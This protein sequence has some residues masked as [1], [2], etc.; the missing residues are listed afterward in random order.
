MQLWSATPLPSTLT[1]GPIDEICSPQ[2]AAELGYWSD[3]AAR[4]IYELISD[5]P[6]AEAWLGYAAPVLETRV[7]DGIERQVAMQYALGTAAEREIA[8]LRPL[9]AARAK[10]RNRAAALALATD[11]SQ[12]PDARIAALLQLIPRS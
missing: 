5:I 12:D 7:I 1:A 9:L 2:Y 8:R 3:L 4:G 11:N 6:A 10:I